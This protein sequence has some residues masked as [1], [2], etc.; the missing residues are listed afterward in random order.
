MK[1]LRV[2]TVAVVVCAASGAGQEQQ[3]CVAGKVVN[4]VTGEPVRRALVRV[5]GFGRSDEAVNRAALSADGSF[6]F[7]GLPGGTYN[8]SA[9]KPGFDPLN[10]RSLRMGT[11]SVAL[12]P[13]REDAVV[14]LQPMAVVRG[15]VTDANGQ[16]VGGVRVEVWRARIDSGLR[17][18]SLR[19]WWTTNDLGEYVMPKL[20][21][22]RHFLR[23]AGRGGAPYHYVGQR[24]PKFD[25]GEAIAPVYFGGAPSMKSATPLTLAAGS[26]V[27]ADFTLNTRTG[28]RVRGLVTNLLPHQTAAIELIGAD[29]EKGVHQVSLNRDTG[30]FEVS[31]VV[32]GSYT[33][34]VTQEREDRGRRRGEMPVVIADTDV[35]GV[36]VALSDP[37][38]LD[39]QVRDVDRPADEKSRF[40]PWSA[41][42]ES[43]EAGEGTSYARRNNDGTF[44]VPDVA[45][46]R[47]TV[48][49]SS[50][51]GYV[52]SALW[53]N[54]D[55]TTNN[56][57]TVRPG[58]A[59]PRL[60]FVIRA[61]GA[62][63]AAQIEPAQPG[64][65]YLIADN[66]NPFHTYHCRAQNGGACEVRGVA[67]GAY[68]AVAIPEGQE[69]EYANTEAVRAAAQRGTAVRVSARG[70]E[71][72][73]VTFSGEESR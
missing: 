69:F 45:A 64:E 32:A 18:V 48:M 58:A 3:F 8:L 27:R 71:K 46:G 56:E 63:V 1:R 65:V 55:L 37:A 11:E 51:V 40:L 66:G 68:R 17:K 7:C 28:Y 53:G 72:V 29:D 9:S 39:V 60:E 6:R 23:V 44:R 67:P 47:Y 49:F 25:S 52:D 21:P 2:L 43:A 35:S 14:R 73:T 24:G 19:Y 61:D 10:V 30:E 16:P 20:S 22:G 41:I 31:G 42:L 38:S 50:G 33:L 15:R 62:T 36:K 59:L 54:R 34:R 57:I 12:G 70:N 4:S 5:N 26:E 13:S